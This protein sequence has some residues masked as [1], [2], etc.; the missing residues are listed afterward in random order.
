M[1]TLHL[2]VFKNTTVTAGK[3]GLATPWTVAIDSDGNEQTGTGVLALSSV[4]PV[5]AGA[6]YFNQTNLDKSGNIN[7]TKLKTKASGLTFTSVSG[8]DETF[9]NGE[10]Y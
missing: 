2:Q 7:G 6:G 1:L 8:I 9:T 5:T 3:Q 10:Q 4:G